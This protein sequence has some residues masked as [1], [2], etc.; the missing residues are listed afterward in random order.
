MECLG[1]WKLLESLVSISGTLVET[2]KKRIELVLTRIKA[3]IE[4]SQVV[5]CSRKSGLVNVLMSRE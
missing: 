5:F 1:N 3:I 4:R 2:I